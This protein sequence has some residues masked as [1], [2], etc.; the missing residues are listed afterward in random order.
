M[1]A[2]PIDRRKRGRF[3]APKSFPKIA[4]FD[5]LLMNSR[6]NFDQIIRWLPMADQ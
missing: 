1:L 2:A 6:R 3:G 5:E 4:A